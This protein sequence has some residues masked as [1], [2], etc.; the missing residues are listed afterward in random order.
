MFKDIYCAGN[1]STFVFLERILDEV[2]GYNFFGDE[3]NV[4]VYVRYLRQKLDGGVGFVRARLEADPTLLALGPRAVLYAVL[5]R[6]VDEQTAA[7]LMHVFPASTLKQ[8]SQIP[9]P[10]VAATHTVG[11]RSIELLASAML[12]TSAGVNNPRFGRDC[13]KTSS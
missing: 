6:I 12:R 4:E 13:K 5:D 1:D 9:K 10:K 8:L 3:N 2:W 11:R 7:M